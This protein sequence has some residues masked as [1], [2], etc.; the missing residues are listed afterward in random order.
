MKKLLAFLLAILPVMAAAQVCAVSATSLAFGA[1]D[2]FSAT[3]KDSTSSITVSTCIVSYQIGLDA[4]TASGAT[5]TTR[6]MSSGA[7]RMNYSLYRDAARTLNWGNTLGVDTLSTSG[8]AT[9]TVYGR[10]PAS[11]NLPPGSYADTIT[12]TV[13]F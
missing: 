11:Q 3:P 4:G 7:N 13:T 1:Y 2:P 10:I 12:V 9:H 6:Q 5:V 8:S